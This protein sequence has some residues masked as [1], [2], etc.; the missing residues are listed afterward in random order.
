MSILKQHGLSFTSE[1]KDAVLPVIDKIW[2]LASTS[3]QQGV[4]ALE[5]LANHE[6]NTFL[7]LGISLVVDS[8]SPEAI[9]E[10]LNNLIWTRPR[11]NLE[12]LECIIIMKG[13]LLILEGELP[14][15]TELRLASLLGEEYVM[16]TDYFKMLGKG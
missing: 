5:R 4:L 3:R 12:I 9:E 16:D 7:R 15:M 8:R 14:E 1:E 2:S 13:I 6:K 10:I 11:N